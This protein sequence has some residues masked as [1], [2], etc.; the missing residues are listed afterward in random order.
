MMGVALC[1]AM[2]VIVVSVMNGF[3]EKIETAAKGLFGD[4]VIEGSGSYG[5]GRYDEFIA[6]LKGGEFPLQTQFKAASGDDGTVVFTANARP[7]DMWAMRRGSPDDKRDRKISLPGKATLRADAKKLG[8]LSGRFELSEA[9]EL[10]FLPDSASASLVPQNSGTGLILTDCRVELPPAVAQ[11][12][13]ASPF[14]FTYGE[15]RI[16]G[17]THYR[18][19]V[20]IAGIRLPQ[21]AEVSDFEDGLFVQG[22]QA[23]WTFDPPIALMRKRIEED[24]RNIGR[25]LE[26]EIARRNSEGA[27]GEGPLPERL[28]NAMYFHDQGLLILQNAERFQKPLRDAV[29]EL[30]QAEKSGAAE[31]RKEQ[32][33]AKLETLVERSGL[34]PPDQRVILGLGLPGLS[35]R[36]EKGETIRILVPGHQVVLYIWPLSGSDDPT[37]ITPNVRRLTIVDDNKSGVSSIDSRM[38]YLP[39]DTLQELNNMSAT[40]S[41]GTPSEIVEPARCSQIHLKVR[42]QRIG[43][44]RLRKICR[45]VENLWRD[46]HEWFPKASRTDVSVQTW[47]QRQ[48]SVVGPIETQRTLVVVMFAVISLVSVVLIFVIFY[49]IVVQ[50][51]KDIGVLKAIGASDGGVAWIFLAYGATIGFLGAILG[52]IGGILFVHNIN[53]IHDWMAETIGFAPWSRDTFMFD[54]IPNT[55]NPSAVIMIVLGAIGAGLLGAMVPSIR[56]ARMQPVEALRYE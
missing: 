43:E 42:G 54:E 24:R 7:A 55:V 36:T 12:E 53:P 38:L 18:N 3:L 39:F 50:K 19:P 25:I 20:Q 56:A 51:T 47:R 8:E 48:A 35:F 11:V 15:L 33:E 17:Q 6:V 5:L 37:R 30:R 28:R 4:I 14:I 34:R 23:T 22:E 21:R 29:E 10:R 45:D 31:A 32:L 40:Y 13:A 26:R 9:N 46:F 41:A 44:K 16:P 2:L 27:A 49:M 52:T 1:V